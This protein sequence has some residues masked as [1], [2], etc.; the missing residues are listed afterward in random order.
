M[1]SLKQPEQKMA[2]KIMNQTCQTENQ[3]GLTTEPGNFFHQIA[4]PAEGLQIF[5]NF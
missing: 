4:Q 3:S 1:Y 2:T 5:T